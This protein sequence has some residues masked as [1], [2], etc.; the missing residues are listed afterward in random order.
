MNTG[1]LLLGLLL[2]LQFGTSHAQNEK[3]IHLDYQILD[4]LETEYNTHRYKVTWLKDTFVLGV[5]EKNQKI[6]ESYVANSNKQLS[7]KKLANIKETSEMF[8][9]AQNCFSYAIEFYFK[10][11]SIYSQ[12]IFTSS[13]SLQGDGIER[14]L[15]NSF[16]SIGE[17]TT[18]PRKSL[19]QSM[20][21]H[22][23]LAFINKF[24]NVSHLVYH[25]KGVFYSK[26]GMW[27]AT[28]EL[29]LKELVVDHYWD[30]QIIRMYRYV[31]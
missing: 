15:N 24:S 16:K 30:T 20:P 21:D 13:S 19:K 2:L 17:F 5:E 29:T 28:Q 8:N 4:T 6:F 3:K 26:N 11:D 27:K 14:L 22:V 18:K 9:S 1:K 23:L 25:N 7:E 31:N 12:N 10:Y